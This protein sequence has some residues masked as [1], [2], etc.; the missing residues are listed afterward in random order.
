MTTVKHADK[1]EA[2]RNS[3]RALVMSGCKVQ[4]ARRQCVRRAQP[5]NDHA[6]STPA[7]AIAG[8]ASLH[9]HR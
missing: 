3:E 4:P 9:E 6:Q 7:K 2:R 1:N 5:G 8:Q